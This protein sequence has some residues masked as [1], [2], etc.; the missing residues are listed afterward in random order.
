LLILS[1]DPTLH[2]KVFIV[3]HIA[4]EV[5]PIIEDVFVVAL[6]APQLKGK[7]TFTEDNIHVSAGS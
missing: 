7:N 5:P 6:T 1:I 4:F 2:E 3:E